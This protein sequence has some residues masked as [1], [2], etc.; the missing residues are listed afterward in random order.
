MGVRALIVIFLRERMNEQVSVARDN[1]VNKRHTCNILDLN[2]KD[3]DS[4][5]SLRVKSVTL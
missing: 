5:D 4:L 3:P 1:V 2:L